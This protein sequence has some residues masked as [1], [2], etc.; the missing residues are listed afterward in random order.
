MPRKYLRP[1]TTQKNTAELPDRTKRL[2]IKPPSAAQRVF[3]GLRSKPSPLLAPWLLGSQD[4]PDKSSTLRRA[5][6]MVPSMLESLRASIV[7]R[8]PGL[9]HHRPV[10]TPQLT[11]ADGLDTVHKFCRFLT[12]LMSVRNHDHPAFPFRGS[13]ARQPDIFA[14]RPVMPSGVPLRIWLV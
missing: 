10:R 13:A 12:R 9:A 8:S 6:M 14:S 4:G 3:Q 2:G 1:L 7:R 5:P 11:V